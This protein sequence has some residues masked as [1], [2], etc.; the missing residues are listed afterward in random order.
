M[1]G[2]DGGER[3][4]EEEEAEYGGGGHFETAKWGPL[5]CETSLSLTGNA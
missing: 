1:G 2:E 5:D 4:V 3:E